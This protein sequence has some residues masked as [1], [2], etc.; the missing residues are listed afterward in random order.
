MFHHEVG[1]AV[2]R[3]D[4]VERADVGVREGGDGAGLSL[5]A[6][7]TIR[8][9]AQ[10]SR[11]DLDRDRPIEPRVAGLVDLAPAPISP[12]TSYGPSRVLAARDMVDTRGALYAARCLFCS[13][14]E[15]LAGVPEHG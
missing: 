12:R 15:N 3:A 5:E 6:R 9:G 8:I 11:E 1:G 14:L 2:M 7:T 13:G 10:L 4:V